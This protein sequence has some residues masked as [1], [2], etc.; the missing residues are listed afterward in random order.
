MVALCKTKPLVFIV[1]PTGVGKTHWALKW[2]TQSPSVILNS[3]SI[4]L[5]KELNI[6]AAKPDFKKY[7]N[8]EFALFN[9]ALAPELLTAGIFRQ[10]ALEV[11]KQKV[12]QKKVF[13]VGGS[14]F[15]IQALEKGMYPQAPIPSFVLK[16]FENIEKTKGLKHL[17][18]LL[19]TKDPITALN[20]APKDRYRIFRALS[21]IE[22]GGKI[23]SQIKKEFKTQ[24]LPW[25]YIK[26]G[27][28]IPKAELANRLTQRAKTMIKEGLLDEVVSLRAKGFNRGFNKGFKNW[29]PLNSV[30]YKEAGLYLDG[31]IKKQ[32]DLVTAIVTRS[33]QLAKKQN[34]W[35][36]KDKSILWKSWDEAPLKVYKQIFKNNRF[37]FLK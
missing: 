13:I 26:V 12:A 10:K 33:M 31:H 37:P 23:P 22:A 21:L 25:P 32:Q 1:G 18:H 19:K 14:G 29:R 11:L 15:Y 17:Y 34:T 5:Y 8:I 7:P 2:A 28:T 4:A 9:Q 30:G 27:L 16:K 35:F 6:G 3:D 36:K 24:A 20:L